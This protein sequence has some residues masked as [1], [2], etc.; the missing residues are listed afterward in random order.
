[1]AF[2]CSPLHKEKKIP[3]MQIIVDLFVYVKKKQYLCAF[4]VQE[5]NKLTKK[6]IAR[7]IRI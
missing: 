1:M 7:A 6:W 4:F 3:I 5:D 2:F